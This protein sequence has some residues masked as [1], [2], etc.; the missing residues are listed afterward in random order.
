MVDVVFS[1]FDERAGPKAIFSTIS[2]HVLTKK[3]AVKSIVSTLTSVRT[4][5]S[6]KLEGEA[7]IPFP[8]EKKMAFI[9]YAALNQK[10]EGGENRV[11]SLCAVTSNEEKTTIYSNVTN[12][13][14]TAIEIKNL[15]NSE[16]VFGKPLSKNIIAKLEDWGKFTEAKEVVIAEKKVK[17][18]LRGLY[19][20]FPV[21]SSFRS[22][23]DPLVPLLMGIFGKIP[24]VI[25]GPSLEFLLEVTDLFQELIPDK[26]LDI[27]LS[28]PV[29]TSQVVAMKIPRSDF[30]LLNDEQDKRKTFYR[31]PV[32]TMGIGKESNYVNYSIPKNVEKVVEKILK[33]G[34]DFKDELVAIHYLEG[35]L[36]SFFKKLDNLKEI[37]ISGR[38][39][40][41]KDVAKNYDVNENYIFLVSEALLLRRETSAEAINEMFEKETEFRDFDFRSPRNIGFVR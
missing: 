40:R 1:A 9:F 6:E 29:D 41:I 32:I 22:Y 3:V 17:F 25:S 20:L 28:V 39:V 4:S 21:N 38:K 35:E 14:Q 5:S 37:C 13:S 18:E 8:E 2:D 23:K 26:E 19:E 15:L 24:V 10:T 36:S 33:K 27:R 12:L 11:I 16:Y 30:I 31:D 34:R 7:I